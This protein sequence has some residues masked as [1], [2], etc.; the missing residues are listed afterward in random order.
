MSLAVPLRFVGCVFLR[1]RKARQMSVRVRRALLRRIFTNVIVMAPLY[2]AGDI[3]KSMGFR[4]L[5][6]PSV[7]ARCQDDD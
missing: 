7:L 3:F 5:L 4:T 2:C 1:S 6:N